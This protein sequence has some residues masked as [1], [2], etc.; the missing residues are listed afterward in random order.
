[1]EKAALEVSE[2]YGMRDKIFFY[3]RYHDIFEDALTCVP[4]TVCSSKFL[5][6]YYNSDEKPDMIQILE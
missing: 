6:K 1:M 4:N 5:C 2:K 3:K